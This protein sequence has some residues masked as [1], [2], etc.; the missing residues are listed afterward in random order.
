MDSRISLV[1]GIITVGETP[2]GTDFFKASKVGGGLVHPCVVQPQAREKRG[3]G[4]NS[5]VVAR[6]YCNQRSCTI[7]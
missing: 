1:L 6:L 7:D 3:V 4:F 2:K 5:T